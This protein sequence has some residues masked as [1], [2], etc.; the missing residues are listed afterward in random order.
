MLH[1]TATLQNLL[2]LLRAAAAMVSAR[3]YCV[4]HASAPDRTATHAWQCST[5][6]ARAP[7]CDMRAAPASLSSLRRVLP[8]Y[9]AGSPMARRRRRRVHAR[10]ARD[11]RLRRRALCRP[12]PRAFAAHSTAPAAA[13]AAARTQAGASCVCVCAVVQRARA[14]FANFRVCARVVLCACADAAR[15]APLFECVLAVPAAAAAAPQEQRDGG[16]AHAAA[17]SVVG[18]GAVDTRVTRASRDEVARTLSRTRCKRH[19]RG[20]LKVVSIPLESTRRSRRPRTDR[21]HAH[22]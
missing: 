18:L 11:A 14:C 15:R 10:H 20:C 22:I 5:S 2:F 4:W 7:S 12:L 8:R 19:A 16:A 13:R 9:H 21:R 3:L 6:L 17:R 1:R